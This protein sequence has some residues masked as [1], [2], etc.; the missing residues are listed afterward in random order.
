MRDGETPPVHLPTDTDCEV[1]SFISAQACIYST[2]RDDCRN[3]NID[4]HIPKPADRARI[5][6][7]R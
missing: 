1:L 6:E 7:K 4:V 5:I 3:G 2:N